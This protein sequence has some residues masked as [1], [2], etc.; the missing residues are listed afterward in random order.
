MRETGV[1]LWQ[2]GPR[3]GA[4]PSPRLREEGEKQS[5]EKSNRLLVVALRRS[6][7]GRPRN[8]FK[9]SFIKKEKTSGYYTSRAIPSPPSQ[10]TFKRGS[11]AFIRGRGVIVGQKT[12]PCLSSKIFNRS[13]ESAVIVADGKSVSSRGGQTPTSPRQFVCFSHK[14]NF[15]LS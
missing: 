5:A 4:R 7:E 15:L 10:P 6:L 14:A 1:E 12:P 13:S 8:E 2:R 11:Q 3:V 9:A